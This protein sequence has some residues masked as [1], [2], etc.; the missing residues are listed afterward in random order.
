MAARKNRS[1]PEIVRQRIRTTQLVK[2]L[3]KYALGELEQGKVVDLSQGQIR[4][5][6]VLLKKAVPDLSAIEH[7]GEITQRTVT[8]LTE[9]QLEHIAAGGSAGAA[10]TQTSAQDESS[11]H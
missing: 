8:E 3:Q 11:V 10:E 2:R 4:A 5:I 6:E 7:S 9:A 1:H